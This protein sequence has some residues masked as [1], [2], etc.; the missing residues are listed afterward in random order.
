MS[1]DVLVSEEADPS[2]FVD[3]GSTKDGA[4]V[5]INSND[6]VSSEVRLL[7]ARDPNASPVLIEPRKLGI[8]YFVEHYA[9]RPAVIWSDVFPCCELVVSFFRVRCSC[10][11]DVTMLACQSIITTQRFTPSAS[12]FV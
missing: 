7:D 9:V 3:L 2:W 6:R 12:I 11:W 10:C 8:Q 4:F 1:T 5:T